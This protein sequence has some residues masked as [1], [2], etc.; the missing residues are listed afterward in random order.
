M[1]AI[2]WSDIHAHLRKRFQ[3]KFNTVIAYLD[4]R[5]LRNY[6]SLTL[7]CVEAGRALTYNYIS[8]IATKN[9]HR[10]LVV[11]INVCVYE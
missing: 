7:N 8:R 4:I 11:G 10:K 6:H 3:T 5:P 1:G 2:F 9:L